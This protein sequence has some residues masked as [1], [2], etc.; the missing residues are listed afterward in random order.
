M[1]MKR[2]KGPRVQAKI[3]G[4]GY[5]ASG[6]NGRT[7][8]DAFRTGDEEDLRAS[9]RDIRRRRVRASGGDIGRASVQPEAVG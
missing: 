7:A 8:R 5:R 2:A 3:Y 1:K 4:P 6:G 9:V